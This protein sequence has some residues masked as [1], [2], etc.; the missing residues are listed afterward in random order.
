MLSLSHFLSGIFDHLIIKGQTCPRVTKKCNGKNCLYHHELVYH[1]QSNNYSFLQVAC[2]IN[3]LG[4][5]T[6]GEELMNL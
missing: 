2:F 4:L 5:T 1:L 3:F 6:L